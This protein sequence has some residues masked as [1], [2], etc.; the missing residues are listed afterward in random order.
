MTR[1]QVLCLL[2]KGSAN[3]HV[4]FS[5]ISRIS[6][7]S[8]RELLEVELANERD[9]LELISI[10]VYDNKEDEEMEVG[11]NAEAESIDDADKSC[12]VDSSLS[13]SSF[14][15]RISSAKGS[16]AHNYSVGSRCECSREFTFTL[17]GY[18]D[19]TEP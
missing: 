15:S 9:E 7:N 11:Q 13:L 6:I 4:P 1:F 12:K 10:P 17:H 14:S 8:N 3:D 18:I 5:R 19:G 2:F 16:H